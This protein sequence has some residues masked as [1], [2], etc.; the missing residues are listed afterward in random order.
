MKT[1]NLKNELAEKTSFK[2]QKNEIIIIKQKTSVCTICV[3]NINY[4]QCE[5]DISTIHFVDN[6]KEI[7]VSK[8]LKRFEEELKSYGFCR[9]FHNTL[10]NN[11]QIFE[12]KSGYN[13][14]IIMKNNEKVAL[15]RRKV[16]KI[17]QFMD[18]E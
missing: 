6:R 14:V 10:I 5:G 15:S 12:L 8:R 11:A 17:K 7:I 16:V 18:V 3:E 9:T 13:R 4:I 2:Q 1:L